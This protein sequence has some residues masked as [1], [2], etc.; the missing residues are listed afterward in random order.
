MTLLSALLDIK[1]QSADQKNSLTA[2]FLPC[3]D[4]FQNLL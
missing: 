2:I 4:K 3:G 1:V